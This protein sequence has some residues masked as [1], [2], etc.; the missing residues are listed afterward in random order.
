MKLLESDIKLKIYELK[1][2][3]NAIILAHNY[4]VREV[5]E[6]ADYIGDSL[7]LSRAAK[8]TGKSVI[9]FAGVHFMAETAKIIN[10]DKVV[11]LPDLESGCGL[12]DM[13][14]P[15]DVIELKKKHPDAV[16]VCYVNTSAAVKA[17][18]D[19]CCTSSNAVKVVQSLKEKKIVFIPDKNLGNYVKSKVP[20]KEFILWEGF[21]PVHKKITVQDV[22]ETKLAHPDSVF[23]AHPE[24][25]PEVL[26]MADYVFSTGGMMKFVK[27]AKEKSFI[28]ATEAGIINRMRIENPDKKFYPVSLKGFCCEGSLCEHMKRNTLE[29][30]YNSLVTLTPQIEIPED[31]LIKAKLAIDRMLEVS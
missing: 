23:I 5:Q 10:P 21:C 14:T 19:I 29:K 20:D 11:I 16:I 28:I 25:D 31:I 13:I 2:E 1:K 17:V 26:N 9:V 30:I 7:E 4:Q 22:V 6:V 15:E 18:S 24:C 8:E 12:A 27:T 3:R